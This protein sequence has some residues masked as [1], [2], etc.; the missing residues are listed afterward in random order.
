MKG[1]EKMALRICPNCG[2][3]IRESAKFCPRCGRNLS[4]AGDQSFDFPRG[5]YERTAY[6]DFGET[7]T[8]IVDQEGDETFIINR[9]TGEIREEDETVVL[10]KYDYGKP[11]EDETVILK[12]E[13]DNRARR[14]RYAKD[15]DYQEKKS[16]SREEEWR[17]S[18]WVLEDDRDSRDS[19]NKV[20]IIGGVAAILVL[21]ALIIVLGR[22]ILGGKK[23]TPKADSK[24]VE[25]TQKI[26][27]GTE[28]E[29]PADGDVPAATTQATV[30]TAAAPPV[31]TP[32][33]GAQ[34][35]SLD[36][37][38]YSN[39]PDYD[40]VANPSNYNIVQVNNE[41]SF[42]YPRDFFERVEQEGNNYTFYTGNDTATLIVREEV[43][44][45]SDPIQNVRA[46]YNDMF[47]KVDANSQVT[48]VH[49]VSEELKGGW[50]HAL[51][52]GDYNGSYDS[53]YY[54]VV[55]NGSSVYSVRFDYETLEPGVYYNPQNYMID[56]I[57][58]L[59]EHS[60]T[61]YLIRNYNQ[62]LKDDMGTKR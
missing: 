28:A 17:N 44:L 33:T 36:G 10:G 45:Y 58:R 48:G 35:I 14:R 39:Y 29:E 43:A 4:Q 59:C 13:Q 26:Q 3:E 7:V 6:G 22:S 51:V 49:L 19:G 38:S 31:T 61:T 20:K 54:I 30:S 8:E 55:S 23:D 53:V 46:Y 1:W 16:G 11:E 9:D 57:Y 37:V 24:G 60:G 41:F 42:G 34:E 5:D 32:V 52:G 18:G 47:G 15:A 62:F 2:Q 12:K 56:C 25:S 21:L 40:A 27:D 50:A